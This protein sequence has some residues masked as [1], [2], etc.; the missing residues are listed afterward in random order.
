MRNGDYMRQDFHETG[1]KIKI[2]NIDVP[3]D[4][5]LIKSKSV[6]QRV[7]QEILAGS[8]NLLVL[9]DDNN[10]PVEVVEVEIN[11]EVHSWAKFTT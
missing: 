3:V 11:Y 2:S 5:D 4:A 7:L 10:P 1:E 6:A 8:S 9:Y